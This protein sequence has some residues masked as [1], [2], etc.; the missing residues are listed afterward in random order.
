MF[1]TGPEADVNLEKTSMNYTVSVAETGDYVLIE[2][3]GVIN[4]Q[5][6]IQIIQES[7]ARGRGLGI[8]RFLID[9]T[10]AV[11]EDSTIDQYQFANNDIPLTEGL[12]R[13]AKV[14]VMVDP[15]DNSHDFIET[16]LRNV[17]VNIRLFHDREQAMAFFGFE[18]DPSSSN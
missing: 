10:D 7:H 1:G 5:V 13:F 3:H 14:A 9:A 18:T 16:V 2:V 6:G 8:D 11:N 4:R 15:A 17:G 12:N